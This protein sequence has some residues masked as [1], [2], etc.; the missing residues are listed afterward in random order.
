MMIAGRWY[1]PSHVCHQ[2]VYRESLDH[3]PLRGVHREVRVDHEGVAG[4]L[5]FTGTKYSKTRS[6]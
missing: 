6:E 5:L 4:E 1:N 3:G 2:E